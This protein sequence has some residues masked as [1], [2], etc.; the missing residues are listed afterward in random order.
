MKEQFT[1]G[2]GRVER[3]LSPAALALWRT[4]YKMPVQ[5]V[6]MHRMLYFLGRATKRQKF[7]LT[8]EP[9]FQ[10]PW[11]A[12]TWLFRKLK[13]GNQATAAEALWEV[14]KRVVEELVGETEIRPAQV[15]RFGD[16]FRLALEYRGWSVSELARRVEADASGLYGWLRR[17]LPPN[18]TRLWH[19]AA[20]ALGVGRAWLMGHGRAERFS[21]AA[22]AVTVEKVDKR[23]ERRAPNR[24]RRRRRRRG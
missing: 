14:C 20:D 17:D 22:T 8:Y 4:A 1:L 12:E 3:E 5:H 15:C 9:S 23:R 10:K 24:W 7:V 16:R 2:L 18:Q 13:R 21:G 6:S 11:F 19:A